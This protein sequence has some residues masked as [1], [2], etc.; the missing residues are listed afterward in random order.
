M[1]TLTSM[2][3]N[4][5][6]IS[7]R[8]PVERARVRLC[9]RLI[10]QRKLLQ[11]SKD[12]KKI[13]KVNRITE[14][15]DRCK[16]VC[17]DDV[18][19]FA[20][21][22]IK[23]LSD[24][25]KK[26]KMSIDERI[27]YK[28]ACQET[29]IKSVE[30]FRTKYPNWQNEV[31]FLLQR[32]GLQYKSK[33]DAKKYVLLQNETKET[34]ET[35]LE[36][37]T[38]N[39]QDVKILVEKEIRKDVKKKKNL[40]KKKKKLKDKTKP[41]EL[42]EIPIPVVHLPKLEL[43]KPVIA[44]GQSVGWGSRTDVVLQGNAKQIMIN[45]ND[46][47]D[48]SSLLVKMKDVQKRKRN[49]RY[50]ENEKRKDTMMQNKSRAESSSEEVLWNTMKLSGNQNL[51]PSWIAKKQEHEALK[52]LKTSYSGFFSKCGAFSSYGESS[53]GC[54]SASY[55][56]FLNWGLSLYYK[57]LKH[58]LCLA[59]SEIDMKLAGSKESYGKF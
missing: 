58:F 37:K 23:P 40:E 11:K 35:S 6:I 21:I 30:E 7:M 20:L 16:K 36:K 57:V 3:L 49:L 13:R 56:S 44:K 22:N 15:I 26:N 18:S 4:E 43:P 51:H 48:R 25:L 28:L 50:E 5:Q 42:K 46:E 2:K 54:D 17:R 1:S 8:K 53:G 9:R 14:E 38:E 47:A 10:R 32:L 52:K 39:V 24:L 29:V 31:S 55:N 33:R 19:K 27:L 45:G 59:Y 34:V 41:N 12:E